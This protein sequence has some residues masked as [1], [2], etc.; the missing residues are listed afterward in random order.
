MRG[1]EKA[2]SI[3]S[4][5]TE[6]KTHK[7]ERKNKDEMSGWFVRSTRFDPIQIRLT[8]RFSVYWIT[9]KLNLIDRMD[10]CALCPILAGPRNFHSPSRIIIFHLCDVSDDRDVVFKHGWSG[11]AVD[12]IWDYDGTTSA[13]IRAV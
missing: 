2:K 1:E 7:M 5:S 10:G 13:H 12:E 3:E 9:Q 11:D 6:K 8:R 4:I